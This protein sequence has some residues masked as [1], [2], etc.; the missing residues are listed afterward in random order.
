MK[1]IKKVI[2]NSKYA[3]AGLHLWDAETDT[4]SIIVWNFSN[5]LFIRK[6]ALQLNHVYFYG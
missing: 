3:P 2:F 6:Q 1:F 5:Y 4:N